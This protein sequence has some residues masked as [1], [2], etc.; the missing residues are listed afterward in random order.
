MGLPL[1]IVFHFVTEIMDMRFEKDET[2]KA[3]MKEQLISETLPAICK[4]WDTRAGQN[5]GYI[6]HKKVTNIMSYICKQL[7]DLIFV[8]FLF[9]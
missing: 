6:A 9:S 7:N 1:Y 3:T 4:K 8:L 5:G 2:K